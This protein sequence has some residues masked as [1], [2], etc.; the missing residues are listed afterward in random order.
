M[1]Y[2]KKRTTKRKNIIPSQKNHV[3]NSHGQLALIGKTKD[4][5]CR[6]K[7]HKTKVSRSS[8]SSPANQS[9]RKLLSASVAQVDRV[10]SSLFYQPQLV[11]IVTANE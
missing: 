7:L 11:V 10:D 2:W 1:K 9:W 6:P 4:L 3:V 5:L 8:E